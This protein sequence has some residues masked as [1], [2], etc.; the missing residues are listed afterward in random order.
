MVCF[1]DD[2]PSNIGDLF[3]IPV[4]HSSE[5]P[6]LRE[7][8]ILCIATEIMQGRIR[9]KIKEQ[10]EGIGFQLIN[11]IHPS[12]QIS[13]SVKM[14]VGNYIKAGA[15][16]ETNTEIG[17]CCIID[18]GAILAHDNKIESGCHIAP[19]A[20]FGSS[21]VLGFCSVVGIGASISTNVKIGRKCIVSVGT[22][23]TNNIDENSVIEGVPGKII[24]NTK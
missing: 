4:L 21:I 6:M 13:P 23:V 16:I 2:N 19:G 7:K 11:V 24:G 10:V 18:N 9:L 17:D 15:V 14:G 8:N 20:V 5:L 3:G 1:V 22:S 12:A